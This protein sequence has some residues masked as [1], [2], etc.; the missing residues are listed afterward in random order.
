MKSVIIILIAAVL[1]LPAFAQPPATVSE[2][3]IESTQ[4]DTEGDAA[5]PSEEAPLSPLAKSAGKVSN[6]GAGLCNGVSSWP[7]SSCWCP[8]LPS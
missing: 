7:P 6:W 4:P 2:A 8:A 3:I 1:S 5:A